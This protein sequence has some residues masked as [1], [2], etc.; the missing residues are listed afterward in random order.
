MAKKKKEPFLKE[1]I[2]NEIGED[3]YI[4]DG[5]HG[6]MRIKPVTFYPTFEE[7][8]EQWCPTCK[9]KCKHHRKDKYFECPTCGYT[10]LD[11]EVFN[12]DGYS[13]L[14]ATYEDDYGY[15]YH[16]DILD[17]PEGCRACGGPYPNC[18]ISCNL[19]DD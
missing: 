8:K 6:E 18:T 7:T 3:I 12:G 9:I 11:D 17:I 15:N 1:V 19:F 5:P 14:E 16:D 10:I 2:Q 4:Y 13:C